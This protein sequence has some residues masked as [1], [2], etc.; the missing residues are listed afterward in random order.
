MTVLA[1]LVSTASAQVACGNIITTNTTLTADLT[2]TPGFNGNVLTVAAD[3]VVIDGAGFTITAPDAAAGIVV[4]NFDNVV[5]QNV[6]L[7][8]GSASDGITLQGAAGAT[9]SQVTAAGLDFGIRTQGNNPGLTILDTDVSNSQSF[10]MRLFGVDNS[11][12]LARNTFDGSVQGL[13][14]RDLVGPWS[15]PSDAAQANSFAG[16]ADTAGASDVIFLEDVSNVTIDGLDLSSTSLLGRGIYV[17]NGTDV[18]LSN[19]DLSGRLHGV[20]SGGSAN[21]GLVVTG[22]D[23]SDSGGFAMFLQGLVLPLTIESNTFDRSDQGVRIDGLAGP[24][25]FPTSN[26]FVEVPYNG[27]NKDV[28]ELRGASDITLANLSL[29]ATSGF[30]NGIRLTSTTDI[31][32]DNVDLSGRYRGV[33]SS[34]STAGLTITNSDLSDMDIRSI[35][36]TGADAG[37]SMAG[38]IL[39]GS[40]NGILLTD[41]VGSTVDL[42]TFSFVGTAPTTGAELVEITN[43]TDVTVTGIEA[44]HLDGNTRVVRVNGS[45]DTTIDDVTTCEANRGVDITGS[46]GTVIVNSQFGNGINGVFINATSDS[47]DVTADFLGNST[48]DVNDSGTNTTTTTGLMADADADGLADPCDDCPDDPLNDL[49]GDGLCAGVDDDD[50]GDGV[51]DIDDGDPNDPFVC[52]DTDGDGCDDCSVA[53]MLEPNNDGTDTDGDGACDLGDPDDDND[54]RDDGDDS[55]PLDAFVCADTDLDGCEDCST[56]TFDPADDGPDADSD[57]ICDDKDL[58]VHA[59]MS[60]DTDDV[61]WTTGGVGSPSVVFDP[62]SNLFVMVYETQIGTHPDCPVGVWGLGLATSPDGITFT[63]AGGPLIQPAPTSSQ[64]WNC[65]AAHPTLVDRSSGNLVLLFKSEQTSTACDV[66]TPDW[67]CD[68]YTG[69]GRLAITWN[70]GT[71]EYLATAPDTTPALGIATNFG[72]NRAVFADAEYKVALTRKPD[73]MVAT[74]PAT[75]LTLGSTVWSP[76]DVSWTPDEVYNPAVVCEADG[77]FTAFVGGRALGAGESVDEGNLGRL[78]SP[79]FATWALGPGPLFS[80]TV[81]DA[82]LR[83]WDALRVGTTDYLLYFSDQTGPGGT[84]RVGLAETLPGWSVSSVQSKVCP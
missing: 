18:T 40:D 62:A 47:T 77:S 24:W 32:I 1:W 54:G 68:Q 83:H 67:G 74:G 56:G 34:T 51:D 81:G 78:T 45:T 72:Y 60:F 70:S 38:N 42:S 58:T 20:R 13:R 64:Y 41:A 73:M 30:G 49:D 22:N 82:E 80:T 76:G 61:L 3:G 26:S 33:Y 29:P 23:M 52:D 4:D 5:L 35:Q 25:S 37:L 6:V 71:S 8:L 79:D 36:L 59:T 11:L 69:I 66:T 17:S 10:G 55:A 2:C 12:L 16:V 43:S 21:S 27:A 28:I 7:A 63:D 19:N 15:L 48:A 39:D 9:I 46:D 31:T 84:N 44:L 53:Q 57:G 75:S 65:V 50:D 14:I